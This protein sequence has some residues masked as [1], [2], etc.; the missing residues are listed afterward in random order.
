M[1][2]VRTESSTWPRALSSASTRSFSAMSSCSDNCSLGTPFEWPDEVGPDDTVGA[3]MS[4]M[5]AGCWLRAGA[6][7]CWKSAWRP[8]PRIVV[9]LVGRQSSTCRQ[10]GGGEGGSGC[11][12]AAATA[13]DFDAGHPS[14]WRLLDAH[15]IRG[16]A[17]KAPSR[18]HRLHPLH[19]LHPACNMLLRET[20]PR[21]QRQ[22]HRPGPR[23]PAVE[24][25]PAGRRATRARRPSLL[26]S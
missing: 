7:R 5:M 6:L 8:L 20:A 26:P 23:Q 12:A 19:P 24:G 2:L 14:P 1:L 17:C 21:A 16:P 15:A 10:S 22:R 25:V 9:L 11:G 4:S 13:T 18:A 3:W